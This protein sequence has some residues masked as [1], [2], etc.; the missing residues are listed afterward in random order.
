MRSVYFW[1]NLYVLLCCVLT[2]EKPG[3]CSYTSA[4]AAVQTV[5]HVS[6][7]KRR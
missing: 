4:G 3:K 1:P 5:G 7:N 6:P 2:I